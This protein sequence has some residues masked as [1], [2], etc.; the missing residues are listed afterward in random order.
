VI[1]TQKRR[2]FLKTAALFHF[3]FFVVLSTSPR[4]QV[5]PAPVGGTAR[6]DASAEPAIADEALPKLPCVEFRNQ[7]V[8]RLENFNSCQ[9]DEECTEDFFGCPFG[10]NSVIPKTIS[11]RVVPLILKYRSLCGKCTNDC[12]ELPGPIR[13]VKNKCTKITEQMVANDLGALDPKECKAESARIHKESHRARQCS[14]SSDCVALPQGCP[15]NC[16]PIA[17]RNEYPRINALITRYNKV[18]GPCGLRCAAPSG[19]PYCLRNRCV[20]KE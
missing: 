2:G 6:L 1:H 14:T 11:K 9:K 13:C 3:F 17:N 7:I 19:E 16:D 10:C 4:A 8:L 20:W 18:C 5:E 12:Q 15:L